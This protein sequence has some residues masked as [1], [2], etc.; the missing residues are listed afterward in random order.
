MLYVNEH[1]QR[2]RGKGREVETETF[3]LRIKNIFFLKTQDFVFTFVSNRSHLSCVAHLSSKPLLPWC[4]CRRMMTDDEEKM[5]D[6]K[7]EL[8]RRGQTSETRSRNLISFDKDFSNRTQLA[9][10][11]KEI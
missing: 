10:E 9:S 4:S 7:D 2:E 6:E 3:R 1:T 5:D 8:C 11:L